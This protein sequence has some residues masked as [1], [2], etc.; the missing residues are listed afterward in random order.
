MF[1]EKLVK[2]RQSASENI[3]RLRC[4]PTVDENYEY[5]ITIS[6]EGWEGEPRPQ[7]TGL[8]GLFYDGKNQAM[9]RSYFSADGRAT[10]RSTAF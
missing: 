3:G 5:I 10:S 7:R 9:A 4:N 1:S 8:G 6:S 2:G